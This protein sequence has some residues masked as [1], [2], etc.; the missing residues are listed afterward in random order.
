MTFTFDVP[1]EDDKVF[2]PVQDNETIE[3]DHVY[4]IKKRSC[5]VPPKSPNDSQDYIV[6]YTSKNNRNFLFTK[7][8]ERKGA[9]KP[10]LTRPEL[11]WKKNEKISPQ[12]P[13]VRV[14][15]TFSEKIRKPQ[16]FTV[17][18][19]LSISSFGAFYKNNSDILYTIEDSHGSTYW[20]YDIPLGQQISETSSP[21]DEASKVAQDGGSLRL[22]K[23]QKYTS[24]NKLT[25]RRTRNHKI[26]RRRRCVL[27]TYGLSLSRQAVENVLVGIPRRRRGVK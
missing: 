11:V 22:I 15:S 3:P 13:P 9:C 2:T 18:A 10:E 8:Y 25:R 4:L 20:L 7:L 17:P 27:D 21:S 16:N 5:P 12:P 26:D 14:V 6:R 24:R 19:D 23:K 1:C